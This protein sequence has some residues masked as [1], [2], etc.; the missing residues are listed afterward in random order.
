M[1]PVVASAIVATGVGYAYEQAV[2]LHIRERI[3]EG[4]KDAAGSVA[5]AAKDAWNS[6]A[7]AVSQPGGRYN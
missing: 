3:D 1:A 4:L 7:E 6:L 5:D 2:P